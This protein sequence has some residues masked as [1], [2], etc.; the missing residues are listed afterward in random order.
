MRTEIKDAFD[1]YDQEGTGYVNRGN[2]RSI[3][4]NFGF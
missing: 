4:G 1:F 2:I 3:L